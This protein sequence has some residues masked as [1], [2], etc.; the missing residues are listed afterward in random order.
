MTF[1]EKKKLLE[2]YRR[3]NIVPE[4]YLEEY[5]KHFTAGTKITQTLSF[6]SGSH[7]NNSKIEQAAIK[8]A[9]VAEKIEKAKEANEQETK[10]VLYG[11]STIRK[12]RYRELL[13]MRYI[14]GMKLDDISDVLQKDKRTVE[15]AIERA[16]ISMRI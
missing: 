15:R 5:E 6:T 16:I 9:E 3:K 8:M 4:K 11:I 7:S 2:S 13:T 14:K 1:N 12:Q 10:L